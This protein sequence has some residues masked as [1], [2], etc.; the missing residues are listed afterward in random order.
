M[1]ISTLRNNF[2]EQSLS[3][4]F[5]TYD[6]TTKEILAYNYD[7]AE[8]IETINEDRDETLKDL[9]EDKNGT[10]DK[11]KINA[12]DEIADGFRESSKKLFPFL[13]MSEMV[14]DK[15]A[16]KKKIMEDA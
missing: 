14:Y 2:R 10:L 4:A 12:G 15:T 16:I 7:I 1:E 5:A 9:A 8:D 13:H 6:M 11:M 3:T